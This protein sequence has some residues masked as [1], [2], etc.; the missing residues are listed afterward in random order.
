M[1]VVSRCIVFLLAAA[2]TSRCCREINFRR[3][4]SIDIR[5]LRSQLVTD[6]D[7]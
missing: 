2:A 3:I 4:V 7:A 1:F 5:H 6:V